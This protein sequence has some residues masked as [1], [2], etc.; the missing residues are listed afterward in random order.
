MMP[1]P[2]ARTLA[3]APRHGE[4]NSCRIAKM[5]GERHLGRMLAALEP[6]QRAGEFVFVTG[7]SVDAPIFASVFEDEG[8]TFVLE[9]SDAELHGLAFDFVAAWITLTVQSALDAVGLT[10]AVS[11]A[12]ADAGI[13]CNVLAGRFHDHLL[14]PYD[15]VDEALAVLEGLRDGAREGR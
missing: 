3:P 13:S 9:R 14:V 7:S 5:T 4:L 15:E 10:A 8:W 6:R 1:D 11:G 12:L 2:V